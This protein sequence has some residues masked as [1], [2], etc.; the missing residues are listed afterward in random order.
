MITFKKKTIFPVYYN[1]HKYL[2]HITHQYYLIYKY[3]STIKYICISIDVLYF[4]IISN[5]VT[6]SFKS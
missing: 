3:I 4:L 6:S 1:T 2:K 5:F